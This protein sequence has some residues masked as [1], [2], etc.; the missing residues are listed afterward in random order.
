MTTK[1][2]KFSSNFHINQK[3]FR[4][5]STGMAATPVL[6]PDYQVEYAKSNR[7]KASLGKSRSACSFSSNFLYQQCK[8]CLETIEKDVVRVGKVSIFF[9]ACIRRCK[10]IDSF[11]SSARSTLMERFMFGTIPSAFLRCHQ[12]FPLF[13]LLF[14]S[15]F[16]KW[17]NVNAD[18][19]KGLQNLRWEDQ[20]KLK[21]AVAQP[22][23]E[24]IEFLIC[25]F[26]S[27]LTFFCF[28]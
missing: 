8:K 14:T 10:L 20:A 28:R 24:G 1:L 2:T 9:I 5:T 19:L 6:K 16:Q 7:S 26:S 13:L 27:R 3:L 22:E 25:S 21:K 11:S 18:E 15:S 17:P 4:W 12:I 23:D